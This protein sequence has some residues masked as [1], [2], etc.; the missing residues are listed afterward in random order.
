MIMQVVCRDCHQR[1]ARFA[2]GWIKELSAGTSDSKRTKTL[3]I[4]SYEQK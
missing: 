1:P 4:Y 2:Q 3:K